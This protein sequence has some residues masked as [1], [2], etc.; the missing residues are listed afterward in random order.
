M[1][2]LLLI[3]GLVIGMASPAYAQEMPAW[4]ASPGASDAQ[5]PSGGGETFGSSAGALEC[6]NAN[7]NCQDIDP[8]PVD[9]G[10]AL[11]ALL[12]TGYA[13]RRLRREAD[14]E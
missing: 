6:P 14:D 2:V 8:V 13:V 9:G 7:P 1:R 3:L 12:G 10:V 11:L 5:Q 4:A